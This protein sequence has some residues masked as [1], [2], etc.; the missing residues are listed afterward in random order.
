MAH[1]KLGHSDLVYMSK[2]PGEESGPEYSLTAYGMLICYYNQ[3]MCL[4]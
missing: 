1:Q 2:S 4:L 3:M